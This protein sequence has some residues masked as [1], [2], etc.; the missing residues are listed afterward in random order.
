MDGYGD[1]KTYLFND[2]NLAKLIAI[3]KDY[4][5]AR[6][7]AG[8]NVSG[9]IAELDSVNVASD[10]WSTLINSG[11]FHDAVG[12]VVNITPEWVTVTIDTNSHPSRPTKN[13]WIY[14]NED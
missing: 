2:A 7:F 10:K 8:D 11:I 5:T 1:M 3:C 9:Y 12:K 13:S 14:E 4:L 6:F